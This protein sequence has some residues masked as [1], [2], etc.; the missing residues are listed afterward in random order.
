MNAPN[1]IVFIK[2]LLRSKG[3]TRFLM[4][5]PR[6]ASILDVGCGN[7]SPFIIKKILPTCSYTGIDVGDYNQTQPII[8]DDYIVTS[9]MNFAKTIFDLPKKYDA[10]ISSHNL[11]HC[12][13]RD[14]TLSA[15]LSA[16]KI[17]GKI[18]LSFPCEQSVFFP[19]RNGTLNYYDDP[20]HKLIPPAI[21]D[22]FR[23][24]KKNRLKINYSIVNYKPKILWFFGFL[25][26]PFSKM[27]NKN[28]L[29]TWE[30]YGFES[31]IVATKIQ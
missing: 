1:I 21:E 18:Y 5:L 16:L 19:S 26:E 12:D 11:E 2:I 27:L 31:I 22:I 23:I 20:T 24:M 6:E 25:N 15:M 30:Y 7:N 3:K 13:D 17:G 28:L 9:P 14:A 4:S 29:G 8:A 10:V